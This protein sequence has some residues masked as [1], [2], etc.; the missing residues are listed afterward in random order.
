MMI[1][2]QKLAI[3]AVITLDVKI[4]KASAKLNLKISFFKIE[5]EGHS[6]LYTNFNLGI[7][8]TTNAKMA[9]SPPITTPC[10]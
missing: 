1:P 4:N 8:P 5:V 10:I 7:H 9:A 6:N 3:E 2:R